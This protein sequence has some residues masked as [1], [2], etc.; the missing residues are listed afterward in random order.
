MSIFR[1]IWWAMIISVCAFA[2]YV[3]GYLSED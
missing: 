2:G 3:Y 1:F